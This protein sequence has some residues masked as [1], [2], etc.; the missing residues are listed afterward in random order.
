MAS[1][2]AQISFQSGRNLLSGTYQLEAMITVDAGLLNTLIVASFD[3]DCL[4]GPDILADMAAHNLQRAPDIFDIF[5][6][7]ILPQATSNK[8]GWKHYHE[9]Q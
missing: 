5:R 6:V 4:L 9:R 7:G 8:G 1:S 2:G 3:H